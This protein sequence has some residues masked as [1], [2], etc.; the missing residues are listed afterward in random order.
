[1]KS[2]V[3]QFPADTPDEKI[4]EAMK[5]A[6]DRGSGVAERHE[7][8][9]TLMAEQ[10]QHAEDRNEALEAIGEAADKTAAGVKSVA[11]A[12][13]ALST[14]ADISKK[15]SGM[16]DLGK[17]LDRLTAAIETATDKITAAMSAPKTIVRDKAGKPVGL[18]TGD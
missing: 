6:G 2:A 5:A 9:A 7:E 1:M 12:L 11:S 13:D 16:D 8:I 15:L 10:A 17:K 3:I 18:K 4:D 14:L